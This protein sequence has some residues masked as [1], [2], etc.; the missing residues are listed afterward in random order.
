MYSYTF[1][2][3]SESCVSESWRTVSKNLVAVHLNKEQVYFDKPIPVG[4]SVLE[5]S[6][7]RMYEFVYGCLKPKWGDKV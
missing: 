5:M 6:K 1:C 7:W 2:I 4:F 3:V